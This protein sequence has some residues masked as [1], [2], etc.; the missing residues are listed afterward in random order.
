MVTLLYGCY[1]LFPETLTWQDARDRCAT[2]G[3][4]L[5]AIETTAEQLS[6]KGMFQEQGH[7]NLLL[8][9]DYNI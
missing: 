2:K 7:F 9:F 3:G 5:L 1:K 8:S 6:L 4:H